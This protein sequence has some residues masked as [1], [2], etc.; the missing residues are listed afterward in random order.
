MELNLKLKKNIIYE[1]KTTKNPD[2]EQSSTTSTRNLN[3]IDEVI[4]EINISLT[5]I[6]GVKIVVKNLNIVKQ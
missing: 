4:D 1:T 3:L 5:I 2:S 6:N